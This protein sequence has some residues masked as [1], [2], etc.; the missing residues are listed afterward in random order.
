MD[1][2]QESKTL[3]LGAQAVA[4]LLSVST[5]TVSRLVSAEKLPAP[6]RIDKCVRWQRNA[7]ETWVARSCLPVG[8][9]DDRKGAS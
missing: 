3:Q 4:R 7:L 2:Q 6:V 5:R 8:K 9:S 1:E